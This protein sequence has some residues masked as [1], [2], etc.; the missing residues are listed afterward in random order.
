MSR[1]P[2]LSDEKYLSVCVCVC[3]CVWVWVYDWPCAIET[4]RFSGGQLP[5]C[6]LTTLLLK[7]AKERE[8]CF[9][10][11]PFVQ[12]FECFLDAQPESSYFFFFKLEVSFVN[13]V[14]NVIT[15][16]VHVMEMSNR[17]SIVCVFTVFLFFVIW[18]EFKPIPLTWK[19]SFCY[20][21][22]N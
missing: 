20:E 10:P 18:K 14:F 2:P 8:K 6:L 21:I 1:A 16:T 15:Q 13:M 19:L 11:L 3:V 12:R 4:E 5:C 9:Q 22:A 7:R 17:L